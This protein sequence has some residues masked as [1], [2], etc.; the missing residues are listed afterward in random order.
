MCYVPRSWFS[1]Q[2]FYKSILVGNLCMVIDFVFS[3]CSRLQFSTF[4]LRPSPHVSVFLWKR[5]F[6][7]RFP[8]KILSTR[9]IFCNFEKDQCSVELNRA[10]RK[11]SI[12]GHYSPILNSQNP[13]RKFGTCAITGLCFFK[14]FYL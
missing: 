2:S 12:T 4:S 1:T 13:A 14:T 9:S 11:G 7:L 6:F 5:N 10:Q 3:S 8:K